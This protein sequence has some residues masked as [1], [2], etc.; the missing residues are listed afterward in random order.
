MLLKTG[1][2]RHELNDVA[3]TEVGRRFISSD[4]LSQA[5]LKAVISRQESLYFVARL[6][7]C[8]VYGACRYFMRCAELGHQ[9]GVITYCGTRIGDL[10][11]DSS[12]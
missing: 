7:Y 1:G 11:E 10:A 3:P 9:P 8:D 12:D 2:R 4:V 6:E 5:R